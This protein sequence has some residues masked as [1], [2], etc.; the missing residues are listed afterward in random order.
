MDSVEPINTRKNCFYGN[1]RYSVG[2]SFAVNECMRCTCDKEHEGDPR[3]GG[4]ICEITDCPVIDNCTGSQL[5]KVAG[6]CCPVCLDSSYAE[7]ANCP[8]EPV[9]LILDPDKNYA[10]F[11]FQP[12]LPSNV[13]LKINTQI[14]ASHI[15]DLYQWKN[16]TSPYDLTWH[17]SVFSTNRSVS[18]NSSCRI[19][20]FVIGS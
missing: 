1:E 20:L 3:L 15:G 6:K 14:T 7:I 2:T 9:R 16:N 4:A 17:V 18:A 12:E 11:V 8:R 5:T 10:A 19:H 13:G